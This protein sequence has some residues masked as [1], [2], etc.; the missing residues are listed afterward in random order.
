MFSVIN[1]Q[2]TG[3][4]CPHILDA[5]RFLIFSPDTI[6]LLFSK[7]DNRKMSWA[8]LQTAGMCWL[9][10]GVLKVSVD[11]LVASSTLC[12][13]HVLCTG[14]SLGYHVSTR[15]FS[16]ENTKTWLQ[17]VSKATQ[18]QWNL[19]IFLLQ[20]PIV[21]QQSCP[22]VC[23]LALVRKHCIHLGRK[24]TFIIHFSRRKGQIISKS[25][26]TFS[27]GQVFGDLWS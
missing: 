26:S 24:R 23:T 12:C 25:I 19:N 8:P 4:Y 20:L 2:T 14:I 6:F 13:P 5:I 15:T 18:L 9:F 1:R 10:T 3:I 21:W 16:D 17:T 7:R 11:R 22:F 27:F